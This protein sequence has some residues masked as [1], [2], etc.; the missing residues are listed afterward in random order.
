M[1]CWMIVLFMIKKKVRWILNETT[2]PMSYLIRCSK[3]PWQ[4][5]QKCLFTSFLTCSDR[6][7]W[8]DLQRI[9][10]GARHSKNP[11]E[12]QPE[13]YLN[14]EKLNPNVMDLDSV[15]F[16][17]GRRWVYPTYSLIILHLT[18]P[19]HLPS[20]C[21]GRHL[22]DNSLFLMVSCLLAVYDIK[23]PV[24]DQGNAIKLKPDFSNGLVS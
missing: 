17:F 8:T 2:G 22:A 3:C 1:C 23:P 19:E 21:P 14:D 11:M 9:S 16:G 13:R 6:A 10:E 7:A 12:Y 4:K 5:W 24:D 20:I 18:D 15:A